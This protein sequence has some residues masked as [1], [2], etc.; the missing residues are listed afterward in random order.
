[1]HPPDLLAIVEPFVETS[2]GARIVRS[3]KKPDLAEVTDWIEWAKSAR[4]L[5]DA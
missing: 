2:A 5:H 4:A 3:G 1:M